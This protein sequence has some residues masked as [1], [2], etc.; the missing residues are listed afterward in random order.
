MSIPCESN[1]DLVHAV[2]LPGAA[3]VTVRPAGPED[4]EII[5]SYI[6]QLHPTSRHSRFLG[7]VNELSPAQLRGMTHT[8]HRNRLAVIAETVVAGVRVMI[9]EACYA[10]DPDG[11]GCEMAVSVADAWRRRTL[12][13]RLLGILARRAGSVGARTLTGEVLRS[14]EAMRALARKL[15]AVVTAPIMDARL[16]RVTKQLSLPPTGIS[17]DRR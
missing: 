12:G 3:R 13:A 9:G 4:S 6:R 7:T 2:C 10:I 14:N 8:D 17:A 15:G 5:Q 1:S 16:I 11:L